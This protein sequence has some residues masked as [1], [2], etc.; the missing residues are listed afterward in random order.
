MT[1]DNSIA[2]V[3][4]LDVET[5][6]G[7]SMVV[8]AI[9]ISTKKESGDARGI[10]HVLPEDSFANDYGNGVIAPP[11]DMFVLATMEEQSSILGPCLDAMAI[12][13]EGLGHRIVPRD[14]LSQYDETVDQ[15]VKNELATIDN[16]FANAVL[17]GTLTGF[18]EKLR[19]DLESTG[20]AYI[21]CIPSYVDPTIPAG[22]SH[23]PSWTTRLCTMDKEPTEYE[24]PRAVRGSDNKWSIHYF[25]HRKNFRRYV[26]RKDY[27]GVKSYFK[28]WGD[29]R[30]ID[31]ETGEVLAA[32]W[33]EAT[34]K[35][36]LRA[37]NPVIHLKLYCPRS[38]YG[39]PRY[40]GNL[41]TIYGSREAEKINYTTLKC[42]NVPAL[43]MMVTN[44]RLTPGSIARIKEFVEERIQ[45][46]NNYST[47][48]LVEA[49]PIS[50]GMKDPG[51][52]KMEVTPLT[53]NQHTDA[54]FVKY[55]DRNDDKVRQSFRLPPIFLGRA[56][57]YNRATADASRKLAEEQVFLPERNNVDSIFNITFVPALGAASVL[58]RS[59]TPNVTDNY[60]LTQLLAVAERS[61]G[62]SPFISRLVVEDVLGRDL[63][64]VDSSI[65]SHIPFTLTMLREQLTADM[66]MTD[67][68]KALSDDD[69]LSQLKLVKGLMEQAG[70]S[71]EAI[72]SVS[73]LIGLLELGDDPVPTPTVKKRPVTNE[74]IKKDLFTRVYKSDTER[75]IIGGA[76][77]VPGA[78]DLQGDTYDA[79]SVEAAAHFW[80]EHYGD[81]SD[82]GIKLMHQGSVIKNAARPIESYVLAEDTVFKVDSSATTDDHPLREI[83]E[84][85]YPKGTWMLY[86]KVL[87]EDLWNSTKAG[88][89]LGWSIGGIALV[90]QLKQYTGRRIGSNKFSL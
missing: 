27:S 54:M 71:P 57:E 14:K 13:I 24:V 42:N 81:S 80:L 84:I 60:E 56:D 29:P 11:F 77:L 22:M 3:E 33:K 49:E 19:R 82:N 74:E 43:L 65:P 50:E 12:N 64:D 46:D 76:V 90:Q 75:H 66:E 26:Q 28:E 41:F 6:D 88:E 63:P 47:I 34:D 21:E 44:A 59:N 9:R 23:L 51:T 45:G 40:I 17:E 8:K 68:T 70:T 52:M 78:V 39:L 5:T 7:N 32:T 61:G 35:Q 89:Y 10:S 72:K 30:V 85:E 48:L 73:H 20:N 38:P 15:A 58:F 37:A 67:S 83:E 53:E 86:A 2:P 87:D 36:R 25:P 4:S 55:T 62:L 16:F 18:R 79:V 1:T 31:Y 69:V